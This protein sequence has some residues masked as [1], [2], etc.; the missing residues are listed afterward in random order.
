MADPVVRRAS[1]TEEAIPKLEDYRRPGAPVTELHM[2]RAVHRLGSRLTV[3]VTTDP[4]E[5]EVHPAG[6]L[7]KYRQPGGGYAVVLVPWTNVLDATLTAPASPNVG[8]IRLR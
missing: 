1:V 8:T 7:V 5:M 4:A 3:N 6:V 2:D